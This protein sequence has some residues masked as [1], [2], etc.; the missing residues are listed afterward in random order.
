MPSFPGTI[1]ACPC[2]GMILALARD[3]LV[4]TL[5]RDLLVRDFMPSPPT[6][7]IGM[8]LAVVMG[9]CPERKGLI[10]YVHHDTI[11]SAH[12]V[13]PVTL[14]I[15]WRSTGSPGRRWP[16]HAADSAA[17]APKEWRAVKWR[18]TECKC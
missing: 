12:T 6:P 3:L 14:G 16:F 11:E 18:V 15:L 7:R 4:R 8:A 13:E 9:R 1:L 10:L 17:R 2:I 5:A